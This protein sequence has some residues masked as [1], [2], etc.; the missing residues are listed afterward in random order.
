MYLEMYKAGKRRSL[1]KFRG[2]LDFQN[3]RGFRFINSAF[4]EGDD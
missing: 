1:F 4:V 2:S 3:L